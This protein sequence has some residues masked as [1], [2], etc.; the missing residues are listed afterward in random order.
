MSRFVMYA[1]PGKICPVT[2]LTVGTVP[3]SKFYRFKI[4][5]V[6]QVW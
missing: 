3:G 5:T 1:G 2:V 6:T 4:S